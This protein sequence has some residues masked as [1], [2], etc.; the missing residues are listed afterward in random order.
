MNI[1]SN[2][3]TVSFFVDGGSFDCIA[4]LANVWSW[5]GVISTDKYQ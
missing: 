3:F 1:C 4:V 2:A 5:D